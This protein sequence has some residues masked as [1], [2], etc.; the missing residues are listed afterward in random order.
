MCGPVTCNRGQAAKT[1]IPIERSAVNTIREVVRLIDEALLVE[2]A[3]LRLELIARR[4]DGEIC[5][6]NDIGAGRPIGMQVLPKGIQSKRQVV[7]EIDQQ[8][9]MRTV[10]ITAIDI[11]LSERRIIDVT[12]QLLVI[13]AEPKCGN[14]TERSV[15]HA[16]A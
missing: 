6:A 3:I 5:R 2:V 15:D 16:L 8:R 4:G 10:A 7:G 9:C 11:F 14:A 13:A 1:E 12:G